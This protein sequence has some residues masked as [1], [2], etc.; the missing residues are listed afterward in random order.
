MEDSLSS[1]SM[2]TF[3]SHGVTAT[4]SRKRKLPNLNT[5]FSV[6]DS[7]YFPLAFERKLYVN[8]SREFKKRMSRSKHS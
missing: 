4:I 2:A 3:T 8:C 1:T 6:D 7:D 5:A